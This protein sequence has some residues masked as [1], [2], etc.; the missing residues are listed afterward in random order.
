MSWQRAHRIAGFEIFFGRYLQWLMRRSFARVLVRNDGAFPNAGYVAAANHHSWWDGF[1]ALTIHRAFAPE[2]PFNLMMDDEQL[3]RFPFF[4]FG[5][6]F[7]V[8]ARSVRAAYPAIQY[9]AACARDGAGLWIFPDGE[10]RP[11]HCEPAFTSGFL[12]AARAAEVPV[13]PVAMRFVFLGEQRPI[14]IA[15]LGAPIDPRA[16]AA[17]AQTQA[18]VVALL[19]S[20][21]EDLRAQRV[22]GRYRELVRGNAGIDAVVAACIAPLRDKR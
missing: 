3:R 20:I 7:S 1:L 21:D 15:A 13:L 16:R 8:D 12:H 18:Q 10:L 19:A 5:G 9:G 2:R 4:R 17:Q 11:S 22:D 14:A 6:A